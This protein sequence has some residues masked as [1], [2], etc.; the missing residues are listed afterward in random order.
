LRHI[1]FDA[2]YDEP[3]HREPLWERYPAL[4]ALIHIGKPSVGPTVDMLAEDE[5]DLRR[6]L[7]VRVL[8]AVEGTEFARMILERRMREEEDLGRKAKLADAIELIAALP[9]INRP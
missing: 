6:N 5:N 9:V 4:G 2:P 1:E 8:R 7:A 3:M